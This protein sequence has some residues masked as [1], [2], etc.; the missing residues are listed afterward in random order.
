[1]KWIKQPHKRYFYL[2]YRDSALLCIQAISVQIES[3][4]WPEMVSQIE[5][6]K[7]YLE[8]E[9]ANKRASQ[10]S[11]LGTILCDPLFPH[12]KERR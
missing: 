5:A 6:I 10:L 8:V 9:E 7:M 2:A 4:I 1:M 12:L 3:C 11:S